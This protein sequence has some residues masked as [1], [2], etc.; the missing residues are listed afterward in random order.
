MPTS[1]LSGEAERPKVADAVIE[2]RLQPHLFRR[3]EPEERADTVAS[4]WSRDAQ[5][6]A[7]FPRPEVGVSPGSGRDHGG[8]RGAL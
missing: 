3:R 2:A 4:R 1:K 5:R 7:G 6:D 8:T